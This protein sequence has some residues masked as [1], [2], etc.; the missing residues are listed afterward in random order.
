M[1][2]GRRKLLG[3][4]VDDVER[5]MVTAARHALLLGHVAHA[6]ARGFPAVPVAADAE[7]GAEH[8][9]QRMYPGAQAIDG[10]HHVGCEVDVGPHPSALACSKTVTS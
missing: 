5:W 9:A 6:Q 7:G 2:L 10:A 3:Q 1:D 8:R 4:R